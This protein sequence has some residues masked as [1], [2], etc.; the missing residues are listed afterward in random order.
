MYIYIYIYIRDSGVCEVNTRLIRACFFNV[1]TSLP[2]FQS[3]LKGPRQRL[4]A[5]SVS[6]TGWLHSN[7]ACP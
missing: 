3:W 6:F 4:T 5:M 1:S 2:L 7:Y